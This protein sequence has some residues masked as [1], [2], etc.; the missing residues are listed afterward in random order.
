MRDSQAKRNSVIKP[1]KKKNIPVIFTEVMFKP[2]G[3]DGGAFFPKCRHKVALMPVQKLKNYAK[4]FGKINDFS[5][6]KHVYF[7]QILFLK[8]YVLRHTKKKY[9]FHRLNK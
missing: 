4:V 7:M 9:A 6:L 8:M 2:G 1:G 5:S 3:L